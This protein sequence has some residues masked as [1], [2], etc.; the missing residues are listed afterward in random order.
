[1]PFAIADDIRAAIAQWT[2]RAQRNAMIELR[3]LLDVP[4]TLFG[5]SAEW[6]DGLESKK[7]NDEV[8]IIS[9]KWLLALF[10]F[11]L[12]AGAVVAQDLSAGKTPAQL[13]TSDCSACHHL[14][15]GLGKKYN[16]GSL[17]GFLR[18]HY[19]TNPDSAGALARYVMGFATLRAAPVTAPSVH[20]G[21]EQLEARGHASN[22][23]S[24]GEKPLRPW[25][26]SNEEPPRPAAAIAQPGP[27]EAADPMA[28]IRAY[29]VS[30]ASPQEAAAEAP[31]PASGKSRRRDD[32]DAQPAPAATAASVAPAAGL[33]QRIPTPC[34]RRRI[35]AAG[36][37]KCRQ[38]RSVISRLSPGASGKFDGLQPS[39]HHPMGG[40]WEA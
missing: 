36:K 30:G 33:R 32:N 6:G 37:I 2:S 25:P 15:K 21:V 7:G 39:C 31:N 16:T 27:T 28:R 35:A 5:L 38:P 18:A 11:M 4:T 24:D 23:S 14:P 12:A 19:T 1:V 22:L 17:T 34:H 13:F 9:I 3:M 8:N 29:A 20:E 26:Q 40:A 10:A